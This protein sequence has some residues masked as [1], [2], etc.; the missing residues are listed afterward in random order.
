MQSEVQ[1]LPRVE[2]RSGFAR[3]TLYQKIKEGLFPPPVSIGARAVGWL[4]NEIDAWLAA[5]I[6]GKTDDEIRV[7]VKELVSRRAAANVTDG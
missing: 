4:S 6:A 1:R 3:S 2:E 5:R 7:L